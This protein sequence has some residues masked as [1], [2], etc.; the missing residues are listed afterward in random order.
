M[1]K[2]IV[3]VKVNEL[4]LKK[5]LLGFK[6][7]PNT[8]IALHNLLAKTVNPWVPFREGPLSQNIEVTPE[9]VRYLQPYARRQY[10][11]VDFKHTKDFHPLASAKWDEEAMVTQRDSFI[12][13]AKDIIV[14]RINNG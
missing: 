9:H 4:K 8:M 1:S 6:D 11:G 7:D 12:S 13:Q 5:K 14:R 3:N 10:Y 2:I